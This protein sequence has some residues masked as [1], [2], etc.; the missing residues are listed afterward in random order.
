MSKNN[1]AILHNEEIQAPDKYKVHTLET[2]SV[3]ADE[4]CDNIYIGDLMDYISPTTLKEITETIISKL[5][6]GGEIH[7][8]APDLLQLCWY[9]SRLNLHLSKTRYVLYGSNKIACYCMD[10]I[11]LALKNL[12]TTSVVSATYAN[13]YEYSIT[14]RKND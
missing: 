4:S 14:A 8:K 1:I 11:I 13:G 7:I 10:E 5:R 6:K 9:S 3:L 12:G 2:Y